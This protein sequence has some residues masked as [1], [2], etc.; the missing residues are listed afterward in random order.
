M[1]DIVLTIPLHLLNNPAILGPLVAGVTLA[2]SHPKVCGTY[3]VL[4][5]R[6]LP[7]GAETMDKYAPQFNDFLES[8]QAA[9]AAAALADAQKATAIRPPPSKCPTRFHNTQTNQSDG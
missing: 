3:F 6:K 2:G 4:G 1:Q 7:G 5:L 9:N 8:V